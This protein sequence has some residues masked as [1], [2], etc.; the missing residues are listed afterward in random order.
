MELEND[1]ELTQ[2]DLTNQ[3]KSYED[4][5]KLLNEELSTLKVELKSITET[6]KVATEELQRI[7][8]EKAIKEAKKLEI[9]NKIKKK[10]E[11]KQRNLLVYRLQHETKIREQYIA[12][13]K[14]ME[15]RAQPKPMDVEQTLFHKYKSIQDIS[16]RAYNILLDL[17]MI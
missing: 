10:V 4:V 6:A 12:K 2:N 13:Q 8:E 3:K 11:S 15:A 9:I 5:T 7:E 17:K 14:D 16:E 1:L